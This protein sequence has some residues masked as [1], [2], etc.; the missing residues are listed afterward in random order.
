M[1]QKS[2]YEN[3]SIDFSEDLEIFDK[4]YYFIFNKNDEIYL[5]QDGCIPLVTIDSLNKFTITLKLYIGVYK[6]KPCFVVNVDD[7]IKFTEFRKLYD[8]N[9][10]D[11]RMATRAI[12]VSRWYRS[13]QYC[14][15]CGTKTVLDDN[16]MM[17]KCPKCGQVHYT[18]ISPAVIVA[19]T[20][21]DQLLMA[22]HTYHKFDRYALIAGFVEAGESIE[23][24]LHREV[25]EEVGIKVKNLKYITSQSWPYPN[26][27]MIGFTAEYDSGD[28]RVDNVEISSAK[29]FN[30]E[31]IERLPSEISI[32]AYLVNRFLDK[33]G[34]K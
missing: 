22:K 33:Y 18:R 19:I 27:L 9:E 28:I 14:G 12:L 3:Y 26:S 29:W 1:N 30:P 15:A 16:D 17:L 23:E 21:D 24:A 8:I 32:S 11:Y 10:D 20:K 4:A 13:H 7:D 25:M 31:D 2:L 6:D 5:T 34:I